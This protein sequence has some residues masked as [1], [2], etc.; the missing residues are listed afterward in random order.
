MR[1]KIE[2]KLETVRSRG[3]I[4][5]GQVASLTGFFAVPKG[6]L[7]ICMVYNATQEQIE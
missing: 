7:D 2:A 1:K 3:Y 6:E 5:S 4:S